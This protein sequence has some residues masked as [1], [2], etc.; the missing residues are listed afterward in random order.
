MTRAV[1][2][3]VGVEVGEVVLLGWWEVGLRPK[4]SLALAANATTVH[5]TNRWLELEVEV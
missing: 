2:C 1:V 5:V 3:V 4:S